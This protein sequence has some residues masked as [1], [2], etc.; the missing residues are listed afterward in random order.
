MNPME[1]RAGRLP[2]FTQFSSFLE[3]DGYQPL[4]DG[5][6]HFVRPGR[7]HE[8]VSVTMTST[9][10]QLTMKENRVSVTV[11]CQ[12]PLHDSKIYSACMYLYNQAK[13]RI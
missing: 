8:S 12:A 9:E 1:S 2:W 10:F 3:K 4:D 11:T 13:A 5:T 6:V 7:P